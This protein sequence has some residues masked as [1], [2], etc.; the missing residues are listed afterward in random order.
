[1]TSHT[2]RPWRMVNSPRWGAIFSAHRIDVTKGRND[3]K[4][5]DRRRTQT[6]RA[7]KTPRHRTN[8]QHILNAAAR[9]HLERHQQKQIRRERKHQIQPHLCRLRSHP[10]RL[11]R[12]RQR[13]LL[14]LQQ[15]IVHRDNG[16]ENQADCHSHCNRRNHRKP[17]HTPADTTI[18]RPQQQCRENG[19]NEI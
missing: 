17:N 4:R 13:S 5:K 14:R 10:P 9:L 6:L 16:Q 18:R 11:P 2:L 3:L 7:G 12:Q 8:P 15:I 1:M 19:P